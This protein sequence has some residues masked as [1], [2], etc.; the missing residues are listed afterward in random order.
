MKAQAGSARKQD[1]EPLSGVYTI[2]PVK[3]QKWLE[4]MPIN[5]PLSWP[6]IRRLADHMTKGNWRLNGEAI[7]F[8]DKG[9]M[10]D[11][12]HRCNAV[13]LSGC[14][15]KSFV[16]CGIKDDEAYEYID[17]CQ[18]MRGADQIA[19]TKGV[20]NAR[21]VAGAARNLLYWE[22]A[23]NINQ[24]ARFIKHSGYIHPAEIARKAEDIE[25]ECDRMT[26][27]IGRKMLGYSGVSS[28]FL[29]SL[30]ILDRT[31]PAATKTFCEKVKT[32]V[33][34]GVSDPCL[35]FRDR[36]ISGILA[37]NNNLRRAFVVALTF[38]AWNYHKSSR[39]IRVLRLSLD[40]AHPE[41]FP[42]PIGSR[43]DR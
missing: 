11:G 25:Y 42:V 19:A 23:Q 8:N 1:A 12:Q 15:I 26:A 18:R 31:D 2:N 6:H 27:M 4:T 20:R 35:V 14:E 24:F 13:V 7:I 43:F 33:V 30:I 9:E 5:R 10:I 32:G 39:P 17:T 16:N 21:R 34:D 29:A 37:R 41:A 3:A 22:K 40:G 36:L 28:L 38:K